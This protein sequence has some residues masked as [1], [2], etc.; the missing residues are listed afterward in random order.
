MFKVISITNQLEIWKQ[1]IDN[2][3]FIIYEWYTNKILVLGVLFI[4][5]VSFKVKTL[6]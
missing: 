5:V 3:I 2:W 4:R 6:N 1:I